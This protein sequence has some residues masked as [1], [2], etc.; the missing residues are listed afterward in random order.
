MVDLRWTGSTDP[1][2]KSGSAYATIGGIERLPIQLPNFAIY[3]QV[4]KLLELS[5][6][7]G[8][9]DGRTN[10]INEVKRKIGKILGED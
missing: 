5:Y 3:Q 4:Q 7:Q 2:D 1:E 6:S 8:H 9:R 10:G